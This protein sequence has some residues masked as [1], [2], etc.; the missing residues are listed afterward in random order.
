MHPPNVFGF[1]KIS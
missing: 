1:A